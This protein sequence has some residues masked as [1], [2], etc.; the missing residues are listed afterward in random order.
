MIKYIAHNDID[1]SLWDAC[2]QNSV[3]GL[4]YA[5]S[6][7]L[8]T[9]C[10]QWDALVEDDYKSVMPLPYAKKYNF[11]YI[12]PPPFSQ[13]LG[14]F[15]T[16][17]INNELVNSFL[18]AIP[19]K[20]RYVEMNLNTLNRIKKDAAF[21]TSQ[22]VTHLLDLIPSYEHLYSN[23]NSQTKRNLKKALSFSLTISKKTEP[24]GVINLFRH[25][26]GKEYKQPPAYYKLL[27]TL[28][29]ACIK[30]NMGQCWGVYTREKEL[31]AGAFFIGSNK[32]VVFLF[33]GVSE[34][35]YE[36]HAMTYLINRFIENNAQRDITFDFE[37]SANPDIARFYKGF[38]S[39]ESHFIQAR[40]NTLPSPAKW[41]KELQFKRKSLS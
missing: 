34:K 29:Q 18:D 17:K 16:S 12:Y 39:K 23:Y 41:I 22:L 11:L 19:A 25:N 5:F 10:P 36:T 26:R 40:K 32:R 8:D 20:F 3:N 35:G 24:Q 37:G 31:C 14:I 28:M 9:V 30:R 15:S 1:K 6:W 2:I 33:S 27:N 21:K 13:Q 38:G 4:T 7:Y